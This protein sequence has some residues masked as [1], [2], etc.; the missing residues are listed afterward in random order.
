VRMHYLERLK[1]Y[2]LRCSRSEMGYGKVGALLAFRHNSPNISLPVIWATGNGW[3]PL[4]P[5]V[6]KISG[7]ENYYAKIAAAQRARQEEPPPQ[8]VSREQLDLTVLVEGNTDEGV[9]DTLVERLGLARRL[10]VKSITTVSVGGVIRSG[11][12]FDLLSESG[13]RFIMGLDDYPFTTRL[14]GNIEKESTVPIVHLRP[15]FIGLLDLPRLMEA[16]PLSQEI[17]TTEDEPPPGRRVYKEYEKLLKYKGFGRMPSFTENLIE[18]FI[19]QGRFQGFID[20]L[21]RAIDALLSTTVA[22]PVS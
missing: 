17:T 16:F 2:N 20:D 21:N 10:G 4:F 14:R 22:P 18:H 13:R 5:R 3:R 9:M 6:G 1:Y 19:D 15:N 8:P 7:I 12:L 11:R